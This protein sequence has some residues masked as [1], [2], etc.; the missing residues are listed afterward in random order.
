MTWMSTWYC[1]AP[2]W[3]CTRSSAG[4]RSA[5]PPRRSNDLHDPRRVSDDR[6]WR[7]RAGDRGGGAR[8]RLD[9]RV[10]TCSAASEIE[11]EHGRAVARTARQQLVVGGALFV[12]QVEVAVVRLAGQHA[13]E[14]GAAHALLAG[15]G[16]LDAA[17]AQ[18]LDDRRAGRDVDHALAARECYLE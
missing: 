2:I 7:E 18:R 14:A 6:H 12:G 3:R 9:A 13:R 10:V 8:A 1:A 17:G 15:D 16:H 11:H 5:N 4:R